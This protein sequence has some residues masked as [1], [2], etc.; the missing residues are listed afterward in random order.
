MVL[1]IT[2]MSAAWQAVVFALAFLAFVLCA[3]AARRAHP[4]VALIGLGLA[5]VTF[6]A[7][8]NALADA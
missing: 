6:V 7:L 4:P 5:L 1:A 8:W 3:F 2:H